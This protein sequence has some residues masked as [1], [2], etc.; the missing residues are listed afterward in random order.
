MKRTSVIGFLIVAASLLA[1]CG[2]GG[3]ASPEMK[4]FMGMI[5]GGDGDIGKAL[6]K[7]GAP[8]K[9]VDN[10]S[11]DLPYMYSDPSV[12]S[13]SA[14]DGGECYVMT[15]QHGIAESKLEICWKDKKITSA[16]EAT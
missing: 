10:S 3:N 7:Y 4:G 6:K 1:Y 11:L 13:K 8:A 5:T 2:G 14:K 15:V 9:I 12:A 16:K